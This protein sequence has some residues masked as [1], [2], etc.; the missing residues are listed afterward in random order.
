MH[1]A[2]WWTASCDEETQEIETNFPGLLL[3]RHTYLSF[4]LIHL[5]T[6]ASSS[7]LRMI[8]KNI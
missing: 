7:H 4:P 3:K 6:G 8:L 1:A 5:K 2:L